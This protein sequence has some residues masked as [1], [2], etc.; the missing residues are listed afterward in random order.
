MIQPGQQP[1]WRRTTKC[2]N[3]NC[4]EVAKFDGRVLVRNSAEPGVVV[5]FS[6]E[7][8]TAFIDGAAE[9]R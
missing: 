6:T 7:E 8:W 5:T 1:S 3:G 4:V 2:A 9:L